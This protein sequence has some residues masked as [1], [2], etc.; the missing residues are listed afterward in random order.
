MND[1]H[2]SFSAAELDT[3]RQHGIV[4][5]AQRVIFDAQPPM[6]SEQVAAVQAV[7]A[8]PLPPALLT[9]WQHTAGGRLDYDLMLAMGGNEEAISW[10]ELFWNGSDGYRDLQGWIEHE[11]ACCE[12]AAIESGTPWHGQ[13]SALPIGGFEST[14]RIYVVLEPGPTQGQIVAWKQGLPEAWTHALHEDSMSVIAPDLPA[15]FA[16]L[17]LSEDPLAPSA[18]YFSGQTLLEYLDERHQ[19]HGL[20]LE[21]LDKLIAF[22]R[23]ALIDWRTPLA[24]GSLRH[25]AE[26]AKTALRHAIVTDDAALIVELAAAG[27]PFDGPL[28]GSAVAT[29]LALEHNAFAAAAALVRAGAPVAPEALRLIDEAISPELVTALLDNGA[30]PD[31]AGIVHCV[32]C[33]APASARLIADACAR[34]GIDV[35]PAYAAERDAALADYE[36]ALVQVKDG[37]LGHYLGREGLA[38]RIGHLQAFTL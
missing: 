29:D 2:A 1:T 26:L 37:E 18:D 9:L 22:Y 19:A 11:Q 14:D 30:E 31:I 20:E 32:A 24:D 33:G 4:L 10:A 38:E 36:A 17:H 3:L 6:A 34:A 27:V 16:A 25:Q 23:R 5:F 12:E 15:A 28:Q 8:G 35:A 21:L 7:C 13:I